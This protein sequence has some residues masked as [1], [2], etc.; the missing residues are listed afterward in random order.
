M[1]ENA[2]APAS[3]IEIAAHIGTKQADGCFVVLH[4]G[5][6]FSDLELGGV[7]ATVKQQTALVLAQAPLVLLELP[8]VGMNIAFHDGLSKQRAERKESGKHNEGAFS[9]RLPPDQSSCT[10]VPQFPAKIARFSLY[11]VSPQD[12]NNI[13]I[14]PSSG[15]LT[16]QRSELEDEN[17]RKREEEAA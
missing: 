11:A 2:M 12:A 10:V 3:H 16:I 8:L 7:M 13:Q 6:I 1:L 17:K 9:H 14:A 4:A 15:T 5:T